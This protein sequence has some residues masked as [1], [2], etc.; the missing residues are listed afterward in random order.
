MKILKKR[1]VAI[2]LTLVM[3][4]A[5]V[6]IGWAR[7]PQTPSADYD[8]QS[9]AAAAKWAEENWEEYDRWV[10]D[11]AGILERDTEE[12]IAKY[13]AELD[14]TYGSIAGLITVSGLDEDMEQAAYD[15]GDQLGLG[16]SDL[17]ILL[18]TESEQWY[19]TGG[20]NIVSYLDNALRILATERLKNFAGGADK[21]ALSFYQGLMDWYETNIPQEGSH[22]GE[23]AGDEAVGF[24]VILV[25]VVIVIL[26]LAR[27]RRRTFWFGGP[28][29]PRHGPRPPYGPGP[30]PPRGGMGPGPGGPR[31]PRS[32]PPRSTPRP[33]AGSS[34]GGS[35][36]FGSSS[37]G[38]FGGSSSRGGFGG[39][40]SSRG[41]FG[42]GGSRGGFGS[43][44]R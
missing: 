14:Y 28:R 17:V 35:R 19:L 30:R 16:Q 11:G 8:P 18:D 22:G 15:L 4:A 5:A 26:I 37:R 40:G 10:S 33:P 36:G 41:G 1:P 23:S 39:G 44:R 6:G 42:G 29:P 3:I 13:N 7:A 32:A 20:D 9:G 24:F 21:A 2:L 25:F 38:G 43:G 12:K 31:P 34:G 27:P